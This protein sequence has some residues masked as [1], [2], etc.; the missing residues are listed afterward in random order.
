MIKPK[1]A[2]F[3]ALFESLKALR[4]VA[5]IGLVVVINKILLLIQVETGDRA[6]GQLVKLRRGRTDTI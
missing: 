1:T 5:T 2:Q 4:S 6:T 3:L